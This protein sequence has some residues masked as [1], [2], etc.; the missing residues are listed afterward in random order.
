MEERSY[1]TE[2]IIAGARL[3]L[4]I[5]A[6]ELLLVD[7][8]RIGQQSNEAYS[9]VAL[10]LLY[11]LA[12]TWIVDRNLMGVGRVGF[13]TQA[14]DTLWFPI[15]LLY[16][17]GE[18]SP[19]FL[20]YVFS[21]ITASFR[22]GFKET[23]FV[24]TANVGMYVIVHLST[25]PGD[26]GFRGFLVGPTYLYVLACLIGYLGEHQRKAQKQLLTLA[27]L[28][29]SIKIKHRFSRM[30][31]ELMERVR[32]LFQVE[33]C[34]LVFHDDQVD[35]CFLRIVGGKEKNTQ[36]TVELGSNEAE[37]LL[38]P[39][40]NLGYFVNPLRTVSQIFGV[41]NILV[42]DFDDQR[43]L[44]PSF[45]PN[46]RLASVFEM[47]SLLSVPIIFGGQFKGRV[48]LVNRNHDSFS[49]S[50]LHYL[51][52]IVSQVGPLIESYR[53]LQRMQKLSVLE[54]KNRIARDLHDGLVQSLASL[55]LRVQV[56][57][58]LCAD[59][60]EEVKKELADLQRIVRAEHDELRNFMKRLRTPAFPYN[61][62]ADAIDVYIENFQRESGLVVKLML[63]PDELVLPRRISNE[64]YQI[65]HEGLTNVKKHAA[66]RKV[67][68][69]LN[70]DDGNATLVI[71]D[72]GRGFPPKN[73]A[74]VARGKEPWSIYERTR[75]L[76]GT[77]TV[78]SSPGKGSTLLIRLPI[79]SGSEIES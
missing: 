32:Q 54:E 39:R 48:Y 31:L 36:R 59:S 15:I 14:A 9:A 50:D 61:D 13:Y 29:S 25:A 68:I 23:L 79:G 5:V 46:K 10:Y 7:S 17:Q 56:C 12:V 30:L 26:S 52:L 16:T 65:I 40:R 62:L 55:D 77:L 37:F 47:E 38:S 57:L 63:E 76:K 42:Y 27:E 21:L 64:I 41:K 58:K 74:D 70:R 73:E 71:S 78:E 72:D 19:F 33:R 60:P 53:L 18:N 28:S 2:R 3:I 51:K 45:E 24:N 8:S 35:R 43:V 67:T 22:W 1:R 69:K 66:A 20:Y 11:A 49:N 4:A 34:M 75:A 44:S 6:I